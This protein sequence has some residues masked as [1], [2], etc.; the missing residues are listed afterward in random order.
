VFEPEEAEEAGAKW[1]GD[2]LLTYDLAALG[3]NYAASDEEWLPD[4]D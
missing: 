1:E 3:R 2:E 4:S